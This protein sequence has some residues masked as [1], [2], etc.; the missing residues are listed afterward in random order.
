MVDMTVQNKKLKLQIESKPTSFALRK[1]LSRAEVMEK[2]QELL[3]KKIDE[4]LKN[5]KLKK[6]YQKIVAQD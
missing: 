4:L 1:F 2:K 6:V 5:I 3:G